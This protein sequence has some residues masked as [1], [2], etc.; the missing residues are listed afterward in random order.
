MSSD[1][2]DSCGRKDEVTHCDYSPPATSTSCSDINQGDILAAKR[3]KAD[4]RRKDEQVTKAQSEAPSRITTNQETHAPPNK[5]SST[6]SQSQGKKSATTSQMRSPPI[7]DGEA[8]IVREQDEVLI[9]M[10]YNNY[11]AWN[12]DADSSTSMP[13]FKRGRHNDDALT[14][15]AV[16]EIQ[17][18]CA[19]GNKRKSTGRSP[20]VHLLAD[21]RV[22][23][24]PSQDNMCVVDYHPGWNYGTWIAAL[25]AETI[26][27]KCNT[28]VLYLEKSQHYEDVP[29]IKNALHT[30]C[31]TIRQ[32]NNSARIFIAN[33]LPTVTSSPVRRTLTEANFTLLQA[34]RSINRAIGKVHYL[35]LYKHFVS[36]KSGRVIRPTHKYF[37]EDN[38]QLSSYGCMVFR[39]CLVREAGL[40]QYWFK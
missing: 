34:V 27:I 10:V 28:V 6:T 15:L 20:S 21:S 29:P 26:R 11:E 7:K 32:H 1:E 12:S 31:R 17:R 5:P 24:W 35:S 18:E 40:K 39:E 38:I 22:E 16:Q 2:E 19:Q 30:I 37:R 33:Y 3:T 23:N 13:D 9:T 8:L 25:R 14:Q 4:H 36:G